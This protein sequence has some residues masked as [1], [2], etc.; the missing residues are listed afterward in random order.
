MDAIVSDLASALVA[1]AVVGLRDDATRAV[2]D[3]YSALKHVVLRRFP[4]AEIA[5]TIEELESQSPS[6][7]DR[8]TLETMLTAMPLEDIAELRAAINALAVA[9]KAEA[10]HDGSVGVAIGKA[11]GA[12]LLFGDVVAS[13]DGTAVKID[14][15][16]GGSADFRSVTASGAEKKTNVADREMTRD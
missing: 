15:I 13:G 12:T 14:R 3:G 4:S 8:E 9:I 2:K 10:S 6:P 7:G 5:S 16:D 11:V 1:G